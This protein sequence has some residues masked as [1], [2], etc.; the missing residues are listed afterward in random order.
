M[1]LGSCI[2]Q[3]LI[4]SQSAENLLLVLGGPALPFSTW[5]QGHLFPFVG[6][7]GEMKL[8]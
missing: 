3:G 6:M 7:Q 8:N 5:S 1:A 2:R 4:G